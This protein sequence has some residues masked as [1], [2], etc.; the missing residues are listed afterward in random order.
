MDTLDAHAAT[1]NRL[2]RALDVP[3]EEFLDEPSDSDAS[4]FLALVQ[5]WSEIEDR[6]GR[7]RVLSV[8]R[9][10]AE[11]GGYKGSA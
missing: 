3:V 9:Q 2:A 7:R 8:A 10:E 6:E 11:R 4:D 5:L 1:L